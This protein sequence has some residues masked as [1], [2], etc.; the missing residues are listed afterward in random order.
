MFQEELQIEWKNTTELKL[1]QAS[2]EGHANK[3]QHQRKSRQGRKRVIES[4]LVFRW[5]RSKDLKAAATNFQS[6]NPDD[7]Y[8]TLPLCS[9]HCFRRSS[10]RLGHS[11]TS[12]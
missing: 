3:E 12:S 5:I 7:V 4:F 1:L 8:G 2:E 11:K 9:F 10:L 6:F